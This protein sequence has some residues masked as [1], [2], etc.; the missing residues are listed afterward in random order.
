MQLGRSAQAGIDYLWA[1]IR[2]CLARPAEEA[3]EQLQDAELYTPAL[4]LPGKIPCYDPSSMQLL[5]YA[6]AM[7]PTE[8]RE[9]IAEAKEAAK[10]W[11]SSSFSQRRLLLKILLKYIIAHQQEICRV[12][13]RDS[14]K[15]PL[16]AVLGEVIVTAEKL[17]WLL[18][19]G[20]AA[21]Q[22]S[23]R[24]AGVMVR[25]CC[26]LSFCFVLCCAVLS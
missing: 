2:C 15:T 13:A 25:R 1:L 3:S 18:K 8:V 7:T 4:Q 6:K 19:E 9:V 12:S 20:E 14:G 23:R 10:V 22:P 17:S 16:E 5:G 21:L 26:R 11:R 24:G